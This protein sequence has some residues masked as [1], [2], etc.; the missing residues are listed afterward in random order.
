MLTFEHSLLPNISEGAK[1]ESTGITGK[2]KVFLMISSGQNYNYM[3]YLL[4]LILGLESHEVVIYM[5]SWKF[6]CFCEETLISVQVLF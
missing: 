2:Q 3:K 6:I 4:K 5:N 1:Q